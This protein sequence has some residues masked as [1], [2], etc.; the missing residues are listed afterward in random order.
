MLKTQKQNL[1]HGPFT[2]F[3]RQVVQDKNETVEE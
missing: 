1:P 3:A 2:E